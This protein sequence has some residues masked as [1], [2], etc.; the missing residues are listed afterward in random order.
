MRLS[1]GSKEETELDI[2]TEAEHFNVS[3]SSSI[4]LSPSPASFHLL[5]PFLLYSS[6]LHGSREQVGRYRNVRI[7]YNAVTWQAE[8][9]S[10][11]EEI[12]GCGTQAFQPRLRGWLNNGHKQL[13]KAGRQRYRDC[14]KPRP[15]ISTQTAFMG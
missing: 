10:G 2:G 12:D 8:E 4:S 7:F 9:V 5:S 6:I 1:G 3:L 14:S 15:I 13:T 11:L